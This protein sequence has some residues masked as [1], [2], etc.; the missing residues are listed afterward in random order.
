VQVLVN[1]E[2]GGLTV[3]SSRG[4]LRLRLLDFLRQLSQHGHLV[5]LELGYE[6]LRIQTPIIHLLH[7]CLRFE[8]SDLLGTAF[9][10]LDVEESSQYRCAGSSTAFATHTWPP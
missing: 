7:K 9:L 5:Q 10:A 2:T 1:G 6:L 4:S 3:E 8:W